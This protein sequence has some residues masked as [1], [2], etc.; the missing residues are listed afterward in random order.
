LLHDVD[1]DSRFEMKYRIDY[2]RYLQLRNALCPYMRKDKYTKL[3]PGKGYF[4]RSL[5]FDTYD[6]TSYYEKMNGNNERIKFRIRTYANQSMAQSI[7]RAELKMRQAN[8]V[9]KKNTFVSCDAYYHFMHCWH[10]ESEDPVLV[11]FERYLHYKMLRPQVLI[12]YEREGYETRIPSDLRITFD[13]K[14]RSAHANTLFPEHSFFREHN[15]HNVVM[16][17]KFKKPF[18]SWLNSLVNQNGL[19]IIANSKF[20]QAIQVARHDLHHPDHI[21]VIR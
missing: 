14:V 16:E 6:Y 21:V 2:F 9:I 19:K 11:E 8:L 13:H 7:L 12:D 3:A 4:V 1:F 10:W 20:T 15:P 18:P 5:Y 17:I